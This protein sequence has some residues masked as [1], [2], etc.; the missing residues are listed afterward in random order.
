LV[1]GWLSRTVGEHGRIPVNRHGRRASPQPSYRWCW[2]NHAGGH[3]IPKSTLPSC[4]KCAA[5]TRMSVVASRDLP[6]HTADV[7]RQVADG[8]RV[9][10]TVNGM[11]VAE[12][13]PVSTVRRASLPKR[14]LITL[15]DPPP[16][17][18]RATRRPGAPGR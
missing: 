6:N 16:G 8:A 4:G 15:P 14:D 3:C 13:G 10:V 18:P 17:R 5:V 12:I 9:V 7:L 2:H 11:P 1:S